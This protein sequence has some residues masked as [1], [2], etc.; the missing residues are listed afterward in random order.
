MKKLNVTLFQKDVI[1]APSLSL[2]ESLC[3]H[4]GFGSQKAQQAQ[5][6]EAAEEQLL[7]VEGIV[8]SLCVFMVHVE[9]GGERE[10]DVDI[11]E[12]Q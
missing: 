7:V 2:G 1:D 11:R 8:P 12:N 4:D 9:G 5:L 10:P 6:S 3:S